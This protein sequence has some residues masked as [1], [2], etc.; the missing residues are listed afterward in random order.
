MCG[1]DKLCEAE[2]NKYLERKIP[3]V[4]LG[5]T[6]S[7]NDVAKKLARDRRI[8]T[9][10]LAE[11]QVAGRGRGEKRFF[12]PETGLYM[13]L[14]VK[15][16]KDLAQT[17]RLTAIAAVAA[18]CAIES[19][20]GF[21]AGIKWVNDI[22]MHQKK[23]AGILCE[24][25]NDSW[26]RP[27]FA[28]IGIGMNII[29]PPGGFPREIKDGAGAVFKGAVSGNIKNQMAALVMNHFYRAQNKSDAE[30]LEEYRRRSLVIGQEIQI[31]H[32]EKSEK[33]VALSVED[34]FRLLVMTESGQIKKLSSG[35]VSCKLL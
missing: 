13:S 14:V 8:E 15:P 19:A 35:E 18:A 2:I 25:V 5:Q 28:V 26:G 31:L 6:G 33:A 22:F 34:D 21:P 23:V 16:R 27:E 12:S 4:I 20:S 24:C 3:L 1:V 17:V 30:I 9:A 10:I 7:T 11:R 32:G 29:P